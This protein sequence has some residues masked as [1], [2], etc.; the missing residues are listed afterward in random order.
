MS[1]RRRGTGAPSFRALSLSAER[2]C[3]SDAAAASSRASR[4]RSSDRRA[5]EGDSLR[6][7]VSRVERVAAV[8]AAV[9]GQFGIRYSARDRRRTQDQG[10]WLRKER[11]F[12]FSGDID[13]I[14]TD[15]YH[16]ADATRARE[17]A[18]VVVAVAARTIDPDS[19]PPPLLADA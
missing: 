16:E 18:A 4:G 5:Q 7:V 17:E 6:L 8:H 2:A 19:T 9:H 13:L 12:A 15:R 10:A 11:E 1:N 14:P 3:A